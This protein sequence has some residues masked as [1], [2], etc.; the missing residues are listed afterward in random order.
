M[1]RGEASP[2]KYTYPLVIRVCATE[3]QARVGSALH[4]S[5]VR[6]GVHGDVYVETSLVDFYGKCNDILCARKVFDGMCERNVVS[7]TALVVGY[8]GVED[9][10][11]AKKV[12]DEM[13]DRN[14]ASWNA[15]IGG[16][17]KAG[18]L[19]SARRM[20]DEMPEK[21]AVSF[22]VMIDG[23]AKAGDMAS[24]RF[25][26][27][28]AP[29][30]DT[31][32]WSALISGYAQNGQPTEALKIFVEMDSRKVKADEFIMSSLIAACSQLSS[33]ELAK[34][35]NCYLC[36]SSIDI[37]QS[38]VISALIDMNAK[39]G[40]MDRAITLFEE[41]PKRDLVSY[42]SL[43]QGLSIHGHGCQ[44]VALFNR[45]IGEGLTP[46]NVAFTVILAAC[47]RAGLV[48]E[49]LRFFESMQ[50]TYSI[51]ASHEHY[52]CMVDLLSRSGRLKE[53][54]EL[55]ESMPLQPQPSVWGALLGGCKLH[56][57]I[58]LGKVVADK[59]FQLEPQN[60]G[61]YVLLSDIYAAADRWSEVFL[62]RNRMEEIGARKIRGCSW[63]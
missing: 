20:F 58:E 27:D 23:Y 7:W 12:F 39:C 28:Q 2:D 42:C 38:Y 47:S 44:A 9:F 62:L 24:A 3:R 11:E 10:L 15:M 48:E 55:I 32:A 53:A 49:G 17:V 35:V 61:T 56:C 34:W 37:R 22:T 60:A 29:E 45:M 16:L 59:L 6:C 8:I 33:L 25:L 5:A 1:K 14:L 40:N 43:I 18:D 26:F 41:M 63:I 30:I 13:P 21:N 19:R 52:S 50:N 51:A 36:E 31:V 54:Y 57:N 4:G 46:D